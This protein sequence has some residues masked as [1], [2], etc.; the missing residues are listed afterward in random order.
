MWNVELVGFADYIIMN[1][2]IK[3]IIQ[4]LFPLVIGTS[5]LRSLTEW[6]LSACRCI[7]INE[8]SNIELFV[9]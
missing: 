4:Y 5:S 9:V 3:I 6:M 7:R 1:Y 8:G 2:S